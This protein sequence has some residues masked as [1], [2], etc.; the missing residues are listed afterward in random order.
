M[1]VGQFGQ[2]TYQ[3]VAICKIDARTHGFDSC[4]IVWSKGDTGDLFGVD[5]Q[6]WLDVRM[7]PNKARLVAKGNEFS[8]K[9]IS[10]E[11]VN[12]FDSAL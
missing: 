6:I 8:L 1:F 9:N 2:I 10:I 11:E 4:L 3:L 7:A 5:L 12:C